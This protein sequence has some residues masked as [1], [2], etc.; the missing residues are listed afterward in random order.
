M[1]S[2]LKSFCFGI[3]ILVCGHWQAQAR[4]II[5]DFQ[6]DE[7]AY[8][9]DDQSFAPREPG[10]PATTHFFLDTKKYADYYLAI[11]GEGT[12]SIFINN[13]LVYQSEALQLSQIWSIDSLANEYRTD[14]ILVSLY[15]VDGA[16]ALV[17]KTAAIN[18]DTRSDEIFLQKEKVLYR[19]DKNLWVMLLLML[20]LIMG[21][22]RM[23][24]PKSFGSLFDVAD[25][26]RFRPRDSVFYEM[27]ILQAPNLIHYFSLSILLTLY[28]SKNWSMLSM[29]G[30]WSLGYYPTLVV[31]F[32]LSLFYP[33]IKFVLVSFFTGL[34][35]L[36]TSAKLHVMESLRLMLLILSLGVLSSFAPTG[37]LPM[38]EPNLLLISMFGLSLMLIYIKLLNKTLDKKLYLFSYLCTTEIIPLLFIVNFFI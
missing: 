36:N 8:S 7:L 33:L 12:G 14:S 1:R 4:Q 23:K 32:V 31:I 28:V 26:F 30:F 19:T 27:R 18:P 29:H 35:G 11:S 37:L 15:S 3:S 22:Y 2:K 25:V 10:D 34:F 9:A 17:V 16:S 5:H 24:Y 21:V 6:F 38:F 20:G 13:K